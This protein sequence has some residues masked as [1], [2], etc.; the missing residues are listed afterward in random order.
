MSP[1]GSRVGGGDPGPLIG[2]GRAADVYD[3][4]GGRVL[5]RNRNGS[6]TALEAAV[7]GHL[8]AHDY[9]VPEI[10]DADGADLV[11]QLV[12]GPTMLGAF[13]RRPW[14]LGAWAN[15]LADLHQ[16]LVEVPVPD[17]EIPQ[18][19][20]TPEVLVHADLH[21][22]NVMLSRSGPI[23]IDWPNA[24]LG[25][26]GADIASTWIIMATSDVDGGLLM[27]TIQSAARSLFVRLFLDQAGRDPA[28]SLL[29]VVAE[30]RLLDRNLRPS[31]AA[32]IRRLL[33]NEQGA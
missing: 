6:S 14:K 8:W 27:R 28:R 5:R 10:H 1:S 33:S 20:G 11:M 26:R 31:E 29:P 2:K 4:G 16:R 32:G 22:D 25:Q 12:D 17:F 23:V 30:H 21:P 24:S 9:P 7:M 18:R 19:F 13:P 15:V 3:I